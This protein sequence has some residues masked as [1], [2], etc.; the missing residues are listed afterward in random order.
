MLLT[1]IKWLTWLSA[2]LVV[3]VFLA[4]L[5]VRGSVGVLELI[6]TVVLAGLISLPGWI[7]FCGQRKKRKVA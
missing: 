3:L 4:P 7:I 2:T 5:F 1:I 6:V